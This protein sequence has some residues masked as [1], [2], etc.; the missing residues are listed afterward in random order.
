MMLK[1]HLE[2]DNTVRQSI[3]EN[4]SFIKLQE[5]YPIFIQ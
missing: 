4:V 1:E 3:H 2:R 5:G